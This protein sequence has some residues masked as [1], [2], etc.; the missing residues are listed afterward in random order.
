MLDLGRVIASFAQYT[1]DGMLVA[2]ASYAQM[3]HVLEFWK[4]PKA[5][6]FERIL[7]S[8]GKKIF[9]EPSKSSDL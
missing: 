8:S 6:I 1:P 2:F 3:T 5:G 4:S 9:V 7:R